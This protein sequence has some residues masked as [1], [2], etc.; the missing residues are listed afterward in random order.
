MSRLRHAFSSGSTHLSHRSHRTGPDTVAK[1]ELGL[2]RTCLSCSTKF[3]DL[4]RDPITC[5]K[6]GAPFV[7]ARALAPI[8]GEDEE[9]DGLP[10]PAA[11]FV[12]LEAADGDEAAKAVGVDDIELEED[13][14]DEDDT[15]LAPEEDEDDGD[16]ADLIDGDLEEDEES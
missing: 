8:V 16:V 13:I 1:P 10:T 12:P 14:G 11:D 6:C 3:Y 9:A 7:L 2:K 4:N 5:P 15:F